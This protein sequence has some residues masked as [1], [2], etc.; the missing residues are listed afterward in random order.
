M[1]TALKK[2]YDGGST[3]IMLNDLLKDFIGNHFFPSIAILHFLY[4]NFALP[5]TLSNLLQSQRFDI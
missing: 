4:Q 1:Y 3:D 2:G 5:S